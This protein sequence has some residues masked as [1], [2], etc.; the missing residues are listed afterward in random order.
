MKKSGKEIVRLPDA[1]LE[2]MQVL[3][4]S[5]EALSRPEIEERL[6]GGERSAWDTST[7]NS[8]LGRLRGRGFLEA[9]RE[10]KRYYYRPLV[11]EE[12]YLQAESKK[13]LSRLFRGKTVN[14]LAALVEG[15]Q[16]SEEEFAE[17]EEFLQQRKGRP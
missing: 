14:F 3:W 15:D 11:L 16:I 13:I 1:E 2:I 10:G 6:R 4:E 8:L 12:E 17:L 5:S 7:V 9:V